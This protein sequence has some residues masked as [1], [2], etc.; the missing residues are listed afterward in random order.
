[1]V[2]FCIIEIAAMKQMFV[3]I[4]FFNRRGILREGLEHTSGGLNKDRQS[5][6]MFFIKS[7]SC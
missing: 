4:D 7:T 5:P 3:S 6:P 1:M 2:C